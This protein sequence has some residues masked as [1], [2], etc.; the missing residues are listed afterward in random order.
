MKKI[1]MKELPADDMSILALIAEDPN[2][3]R[4]EFVDLLGRLSHDGQLIA[5]MIVKI[6]SGRSRKAAS[7]SGAIGQAAKALLKWA[8]GNR[9]DQTKV[10]AATTSP[11]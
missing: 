3:P 11:V 6:E 10:E 1:N 8:K 4:S 7:R 9:N 2:L 5:H